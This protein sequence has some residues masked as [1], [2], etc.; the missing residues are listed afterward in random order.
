MSRVYNF[1]A[2]PS[3]LPEAVLEKAAKEM[4][5]YPGAGMS[6]ME[7][8]HRS[9]E[10]EAII[11]GAIANVRK[12]MNI[13]DDYEVMFVQGG[14][15]SLFAMVPLNLMSDGGEADYVNT[16]AWSDK[17][18]KEAKKFGKVNVIASSKE[19]NYTWYPELTAD[20]I[21]PKA[22]YL[23]ITSNNTIYGTK[24]GTLPKINVPIIADM[25]S[26]IMSEVVNVNEYGMIYAGAQKNLGPAGVVLVI[27]RKD[28]LGKARSICPTMFDFKIHA[29]NGSMYNTPPTYGIYVAGLVFEWLLEKGGIEAQQ[30]ENYAKAD[31]LYGYIEESTMYSSPVKK[32][33]RSIMNIPFVIGDEELEKKF[34]KEA[35]AAGLVNLAGH[36][37]VGGMRASIYNAMPL[38]GVQVLVDFMKKFEADNK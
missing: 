8:S 28:L 17:A 23:H 4:V 7:M 32:E 1:S 15:S 10:Y 5:E 35:K 38:A 26:N 34:V 11:Y 18:I 9:K 20:M 24:V 31:L 36:R 16:G 22:E 2:G 25:S 30:A 6:V 27:I 3:A 13:S 12:L 37:S 19:D 14:A 21:T 33:N 29:D